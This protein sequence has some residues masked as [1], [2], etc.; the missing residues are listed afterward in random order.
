MTIVRGAKP[1]LFRSL[2]INLSAARLSRLGLDEDIGDFAVLVD[3]PPQ[4]HPAT[5]DRDVHLVEMPLRVCPRTLS[6][7]TS[8]DRRS[9]PLYPSPNG[10]VRHVYTPF[11]HKFL[12]VAEAQVESG[13]QPNSALDD[14]WWEVEISIANLIH[15]AILN[16]SITRVHLSL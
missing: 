16:D 8:G 6:S 2:R 5:A 4:I 10:L 12:D 15:P 3:G 14:R 13:I 11:S 7:Q 1:C 9:K